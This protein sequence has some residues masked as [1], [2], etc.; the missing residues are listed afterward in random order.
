MSIPQIHPRRQLPRPLGSCVGLLLDRSL[1]EPPDQ[2]HPLIAF[3]ACMTSIERRLY[4][5]SR[6][7]GVIHT[8]AGVA[9]GTTAGVVLGTTA[10]ATAITVG[11]RSL[12]EAASSLAAA[13]EEGDLP[14]ARALLPTLVGRDPTNLDSR[15][16]ARAVVESVAENT[17][18]A[19][20]APAL[21]GALLGA[22]G[23]CAYRAINTMDAMIGHRSERYV[24]YG[25][26]SARLDD[27][28]NWIPARCTAALVIAVRPHRARDVWDAVMK[29]A[30]LHPSPNAGVAEA[31][32]A[33]ALGVT[34]GGE[35]RYGDRLEVRAPL[36]RGRSPL[37]TDIDD[38]TR[39]SRD[40]T[41][42][43][44]LLLFALGWMR[45]GWIR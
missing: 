2:L 16:I 13:L 5:D 12:H 21:W 32:F 30:P 25:W 8:V 27:L 41:S 26:A 23:T 19:I 35:N 20:V 44:A 39:L 40:I 29:Q 7:R 1:G 43:F 3:G 45:G 34:L 14:L 4:R 28:A 17:V 33:A 9:V 24:H 6:W 10:V 37:P 11:G 36:G 22:A 15:E 31:A 42:A 18:D 38:A